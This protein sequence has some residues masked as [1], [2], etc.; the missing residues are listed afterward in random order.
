MNATI[1]HHARCSKSRQTLAI[2]EEKNAD[3]TI[4]HYQKDPPSRAE[5]AEAINTLGIAPKELVRTGDK[6]F[7]DLH[8]DTSAFGDHQW[9]ELL[10]SHPALIQ[11]PI[12]FTA[13]GAAIGRPPES[14]L[15]IL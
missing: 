7:K 5:L 3:I 12:V 4:R 13:R 15:E 6:A 10:A 2:L 9:L 1:W 11:R 14:V 8:L